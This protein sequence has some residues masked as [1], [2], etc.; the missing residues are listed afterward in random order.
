[1]LSRLKKVSMMSLRRRLHDILKQ[2]RRN[3]YFKP[4]QNVFEAEVKSFFRH[5]CDVF[6]SVGLYQLYQPFCSTFHPDAHS[7]ALAMALSKLSKNF[8]S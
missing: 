3:F 2:N 7:A 1:M 5:L 4:I 8:Y 6:L